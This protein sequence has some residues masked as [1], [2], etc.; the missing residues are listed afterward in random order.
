MT[1]SDENFIAVIGA[2]LVWVFLLTTS[3]GGTLLNALLGFYSQ[4]SP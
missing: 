3:L 1:R 4:F 2:I